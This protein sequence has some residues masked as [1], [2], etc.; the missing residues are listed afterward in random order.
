MFCQQPSDDGIEAER[1][2]YVMEARDYNSFS[3]LS[4]MRNVGDCNNLSSIKIS[5]NDDT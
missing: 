5:E 2:A 4:L 3:E 1:N